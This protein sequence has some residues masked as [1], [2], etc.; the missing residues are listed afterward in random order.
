MNILVTGGAGFLGSYICEQL[1]DK[2]HKV[3]AIDMADGRKIEHLLSNKSFS[4]LQDSV[5]D[6]PLMRRQLKDKDMVFHLAAIADP[7]KYVKSPLNVMEVDLLAAIN[8]FKIAAENKVKVVFSSTSEIFGR[9]KAVPWKE[10]D[11]RVL[12][13][14]NVH[15]WC[16]STS[17]AACE[18]FLFALGAQEGL[19]FVIYRFFNVYGPKL[20]D[21][22]HGR[23]IPIFLKQGLTGEDITVHGDGKQTRTFIYVDDAIE[24]V[25]KLALLKKCEGEVFNIGNQKEY[26]MAELARLMK[27]CGGF[28]SKIKFIEHK[29]VFGKGYED[30]PRRIPDTK[31]IHKYITWKP[32]VSLED[33]L[34][35]TM[36]Y[37][38]ARAIDV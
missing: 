6:V 15:R 13:A 35:R 18:H 5:C 29:K 9:N 25:I 23:V 8:I 31:K 34:K 3:T 10:D 12:G 33:G 32:K 1:L 36:D 17:K 20:D 21:L 28:K 22:G 24:A 27:K 19:R 38:R 11:E 26:T 30:I 16:Y 14:T 2:G 37:Y 7:L 4:F